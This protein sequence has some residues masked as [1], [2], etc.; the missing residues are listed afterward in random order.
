MARTSLVTPAIAAGLGEWHARHETIHIDVGTGDGRYALHLARREAS[1]GVVGL[2][3]NL[4]HLVVHPRRMPANL[5][6][7]AADA[8]AIPREFTGRAAS[9]SVNF[10][11]SP[12]LTGLL[13]GDG[14]LL[15][16]LAAALAPGGRIEVRIN[17][18]AL[19]EEGVSLT[20]AGSRV[21]R[22]LRLMG[23]GSIV[24]TTLGA[25]DLRCFPS[26]WAKRAGFGRDPHA[27]EISGRICGYI[28]RSEPV[29]D[30]RRAQL[31]LRPDVYT[32]RNASGRD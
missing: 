13:L 15:D 32:T 7:F 31:Q 17:A 3:T 12:L 4:D 11:F 16:S 25:A 6:F 24:T 2:D 22:A 8:R 14:A 5:R 9:I 26:T 28:V 18:R 20:E 23:L 29:L 10:P 27:V 30:S 21:E 1:R 19:V